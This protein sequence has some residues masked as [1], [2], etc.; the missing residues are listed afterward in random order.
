MYNLQLENLAKVDKYDHERLKER[1]SK[2][3]HQLYVSV[4]PLKYLKPIPTLQY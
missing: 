1:M 3:Y 2:L 4:K